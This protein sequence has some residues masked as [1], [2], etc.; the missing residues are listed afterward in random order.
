MHTFPPHDTL[1]FFYGLREKAVPCSP[2]LL[3]RSQPICWT[4]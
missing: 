3:S 4:Y 2:M 1:R